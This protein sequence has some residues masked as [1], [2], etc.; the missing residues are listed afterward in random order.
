MTRR[1]VGSCGPRGLGASPLPGVLL[2]PSSLR[3]RALPVIAGRQN[4][5]LHFVP[6]NGRRFAS[7]HPHFR[8]RADPPAWCPHTHT[9]GIPLHCAVVC[10]AVLCYFVFTFTR[11]VANCSDP[12]PTVATPPTVANCSDPTPDL[13]CVSPSS[14]SGWLSHPLTPPPRVRPVHA[15]RWAVQGCPREQTRERLGSPSHGALDPPARLEWLGS[16]KALGLQR[17]RSP[18]GGAPTLVMV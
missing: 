5:S 12:P 1:S 2:A 7:P 4:T 11:T 18:A 13:L 9:R 17:R 10:P 16:Y 8:L 3:P 15:R 6:L 14:T